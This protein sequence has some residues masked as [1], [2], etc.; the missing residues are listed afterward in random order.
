MATD[1]KKIALRI[2]KWIAG[3]AGGL[4]ALVIIALTLVVWILTPERLTPLVE[5][6]GSDYIDGELKVARVELTFWHTFPALHL[7]IDSL[8][9]ISHSLR[10]LPAAERAH[11]PADVDSLLSVSRFSGSVNVPRLL[12]GEIEL[13]D[14]LIVRPSVN[15][16]KA[17]ASAANY[18]I[19][20][21]SDEAADTVTAIPDISLGSFT[22]EGGAPLRY[23]SIPDS[24]SVAV[25]LAAT[26]LAGDGDAVY[27]LKV[28]GVSDARVSALTVRQ[29]QFGVGG[30]VEWSPRRPRRIGLDDFKAGV[31]RLMT[32]TTAEIDFA[33]GV[34]VDRLDLNVPR[35]ALSDI[36]A[37]IPEALRG[38][39]A[40]LD[41]DMT[42]RADV[43]LTK[44]YVVD[45]P[46]SIP[47]FKASASLEAGR[48]HFDRL[49]LT[50]LALDAKADIDG[51][52]LDAS[53]I[54]VTK[55][56]AS[57]K[58]VDVELKVKAT[59][60]VSDPRLVGRFIGALRFD[61]LPR[62]LM[63]QLPVTLAGTLRADADFDFRVSDLSPDRFHRLDLKG[64]AAL[65]DFT[66]TMNDGSGSAY[67]RNADLRLGTSNSFVKDG[68]RVDS[69]L[70]MSLKV[71]TVAL[72]TPEYRLTGR[73]LKAGVG[74]LNRTSS[75]DTTII[76]PI[77]GTIKA[78]RLALVSDIDTINI[79]LRDVTCRA[80]LRRFNGNS[81]APLLN[82]DIEAGRIR[83]A[84]PINRASI[85]DGHVALTL[86][87]RAR[88][89]SPRLQARI[90]S[91]RLLHP[92][93]APDSLTRLAIKDMR[94]NRPRNEVD[95]AR[96]MIDMQVDGSLRDLLLRWSAAGSVKAG[97]VRVLTPYFPL[98]TRMENL[99]MEFNTDSVTLT[100]TRLVAGESDFMVNG[101]ITG[102]RRALTS[103]RG[104]PLNIEF[105]IHSRHI[106]VNQ[107]ATAI[108]AGQAMV[109]NIRSGDVKVSD[110]DN[111]EVIQA[112]LDNAAPDTQAA[113]VIPSN[114]DASLNVSADEIVY[115]DVVFHDFTGDLMV[116]DG[117]MSLNELSASTDIGSVA[118]TA[119]Y[120]AP[121]RDDLSFAFDLGLK[122]IKVNRFLDMLPAIDSIMP[123]LRDVSGIISADVAA[124]TR[125]DRE[126][127]LDLPTLSA[128]V[129]LTG[130]SLV[131][132]D[133]ET[134]RTIGKWLLFKNKQRNMIDHMEVE[135]VVEDSQIELFPFMFDM[136]RYRL[137]VMG[138]NDLA[139]NF[140]YHVSVLKSP[141]PFKF[142]INISGNPDKMKVRLGGAKFKEN[143]V[144]QKVAIVDTT[145][146][147]LLRN[148]STAFR[149][150][151]RK[152][153]VQQLDFGGVRTGAVTGGVDEASDT[154]SHADSLIFIEQGLLPAPPAPPVVAP[155]QPSG[156]S[157]K[158]K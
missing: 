17:T 83:F 49:E 91:L 121:T 107:L 79:R 96:E 20:P 110:S 128:A 2:A 69:L 5:K 60:V 13:Y 127:N 87:P 99:D 135:L 53:V 82:L 138:G 31:G 64:E 33:D 137:G 47:S 105:D 41:T 151:V 9:V 134:F 131:L 14:L 28:E 101:R 116:Y 52:N 146:I 119:L 136:D 158:K 74:C 71:D 122:D 141:I 50:Q 30:R 153:G 7:D 21:P 133:A 81:R 118:L 65:S 114:I 4:V 26:R 113:L 39:L 147:N 85:S 73:E 111:D 94:R 150:G 142:G 22:I 139:M 57:G 109:D 148:I 117:A 6:Y 120:S 100:D 140:K 44:P 126:M 66:M 155:E 24:T 143:M 154:I 115:S 10:K 145:R 152:G 132:L 15:L 32:E 95:T 58:S 29:L 61:R 144:A 93:L 34:R 76:N 72:M 27:T 56:R 97:K 156:K 77:G 88:R 92:H 68:H 86:H 23:R 102:I 51:R 48:L 123:L 18:D 46:D 19:L 78:G 42:L 84:D 45:G 55:V 103:S 90:D 36:I 25:T 3:I 38:Q 108:F 75:A 67:I 59:D 11:L 124:T 157:K 129:R 16:V 1:K 98:R 125:L 8:E 35:V 130:D 63:A 149:R 70:T 43:R 37:I 40:L 104:K 80:A 106:N 12:I 62:N 112:A 89:N 54:D